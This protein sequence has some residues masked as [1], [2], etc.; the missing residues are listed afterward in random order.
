MR[1]R[2]RPSV[3]TYICTYIRMYICMYVCTYPRMHACMHVC[4]YVCMH[5]CMY[6]CMYVCTH[7]CMNASIWVVLHSWEQNCDMKLKN[8]I[9]LK[10]LL[11]V[12]LKDINQMHHIIVHLYVCGVVLKLRKCKDVLCNTET[13][14]VGKC[15]IT[16]SVIDKLSLF[17][18]KT[19]QK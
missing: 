2:V 8:S 18:T 6:V 1:A 17:S 13:K 4:M 5:V 7:A 12:F 3:R 19:T 10:T 11:L 15:N 9:S 14:Q 16:H